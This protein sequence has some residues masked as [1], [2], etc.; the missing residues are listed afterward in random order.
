MASGSIVSPHCRRSDVKGGCRSESALIRS[1][2][3]SLSLNTSA[4]TA[5]G[6]GAGGLEIEALSRYGVTPVLRMRNRAASPGAVTDWLWL[7]V[8]GATAFHSPV[9]K[10][11]RA[12]MR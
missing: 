9:P 11:E 2:G 10:S 7:T 3:F 8:A 12:S 1:A 4:L 6:H 5:R